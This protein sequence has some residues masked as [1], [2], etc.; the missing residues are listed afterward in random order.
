[1]CAGL[2]RARASGPV[3]GRGSASNKIITSCTTEVNTGCYQR[4]E[5]YG[6]LAWIPEMKRKN[7]IQYVIFF[8]KRRS[9]A[10]RAALCCSCQITLS[11]LS[12]PA[13]ARYVMIGT[14]AA[15]P[16]HCQMFLER[17]RYAYS[18]TI[19]GCPCADTHRYLR[20]PRSGTARGAG[21]CPACYH[22]H[23]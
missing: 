20:P 21:R 1:M 4:G 10:E 6:S 22:L 2:A 23:P 19:A 11:D 8:V 13:R 18:H 14:A 3:R 17:R 5:I 9:I 16:L 15:P 7:I 12:M